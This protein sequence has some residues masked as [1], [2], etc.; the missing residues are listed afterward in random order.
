MP[1]Q[2]V[3]VTKTNDILV[4]L[5]IHNGLVVAYILVTNYFG[6]VSFSFI[7]NGRCLLKTMKMAMFFE[8]VGSFSFLVHDPIGIRVVL[9]AVDITVVLL[10]VG[11]EGNYLYVT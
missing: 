2:K 3:N 6:L 5:S 8:G 11:G 9:L 7:F 4:H 1:K 10:G